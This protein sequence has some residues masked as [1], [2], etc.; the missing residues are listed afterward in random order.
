MKP[1]VC[2]LCTGLYY[3]VLTQNSTVV[4]YWVKAFLIQMTWDTQ[5][6]AYTTPRCLYTYRKLF[7]CS[8]MPQICNPLWIPHLGQ[9]IFPF[10]TQKK[11]RIQT[12]WNL[13]KWMTQTFNFEKP[14][15]SC[16]ARMQL[17]RAVHRGSHAQGVAISI[18]HIM[19]MSCSQELRGTNP[20]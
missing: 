9:I 7:F 14:A 19:T 8:I 1:K 13:C 5:H 15:N 18:T 11:S 16:K 17:W 20:Y 3:R 12:T 6:R 4:K 2:V 10:P